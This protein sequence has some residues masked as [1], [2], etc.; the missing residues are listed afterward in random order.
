MRYWKMNS[1]SSFK[2]D[3]AIVDKWRSFLQ[4]RQ[5]SQKEIDDLSNVLVP[6][7]QNYAAAPR[8]QREKM[9]NQIDQY[10]EMLKNKGVPEEAVAAAIED[11]EEEV[12]DQQKDVYIFRGK[13]GKGIQS[14]L[15][16][17]GIDSK[18][19]NTILKALATDLKNAGFNVLEE[20]K[21]RRVIDAPKTILALSNIPEGP[22]RDKIIRV[23]VKLLRNN[24]IKLNPEDSQ[25]LKSSGEET[26]SAP[27]LTEPTATPSQSRSPG[28]PSE[29][30]APGPAP[31]HPDYQQDGD[32]PVQQPGAADI[33][34]TD[35][36]AGDTSA[37]VQQPGSADDPTPMEPKS[38][39][40]SIKYSLPNDLETQLQ[41]RD[42]EI[43][44]NLKKIHSEKY[45]KKDFKKD[46]KRFVELL[47]PH[48]LTIS[49]KK[50]N[51]SN[52]F[53]RILKMI[54]QTNAAGE[55]NSKEA[56]E[57]LSILKRYGADQNSSIYRIVITML[58]Y[59]G[60]DNGNKQIGND[61]SQFVGAI[62]NIARAVD[63]SSKRKQRE[64]VKLSES[65]MKRWQLIAGIKKVQ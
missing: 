46:L 12:E 11:A 62:M 22:D 60:R 56:Y 10:I 41:G 9:L 64:G 50:L 29:E 7:L 63:I 26:G 59:K 31:P 54:A 32:K 25:N 15:A 13:R 16:K 61:L 4:E 3:K 37:P 28:P 17:A 58:N 53:G 48:N 47:G 36:P 57:S 49:V 65:E 19:L 23:I 43:Y 14:Q 8:K 40:S 44:F 34:A 33:D 35:A 45:P 27:P 55:R 2:E 42:R 39:K 52:K 51:E 21:S 5:Y 6:A 30:P 20:K 18:T 1:W 38:A 24:K